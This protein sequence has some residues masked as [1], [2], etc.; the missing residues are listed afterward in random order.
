MCDV[1]E[2]VLNLVDC[3]YCNYIFMRLKS[4]IL[5]V[6]KYLQVTMLYA[7][8]YVGLA[9]RRLC[10][11]LMPLLRYIVQCRYYHKYNLLLKY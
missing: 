11:I 3:N 6:D 10:E 9:N 4:G 1:L 2:C 7:V 8:C 5:V